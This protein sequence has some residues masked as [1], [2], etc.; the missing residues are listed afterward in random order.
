MARRNDNSGGAP[1]YLV[2]LVLSLVVYAVSFFLTRLLSRYRELQR[3]PR[4]VPT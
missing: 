3:R 4:R 1:A 2:A